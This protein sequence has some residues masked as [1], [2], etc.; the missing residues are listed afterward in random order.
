MHTEN[1]RPSQKRLRRKGNRRVIQ[2]RKIAS[3]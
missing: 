1:P 2:K 3:A